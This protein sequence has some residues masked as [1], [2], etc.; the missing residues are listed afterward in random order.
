MC[1][2]IFSL[3]FC[4]FKSY[5][6][7]SFFLSGRTLIYVFLEFAIK[8]VAPIPQADFE[9]DLTVKNLIHHR[10]SLTDSVGGYHLSPPL[11]NASFFQLLTGSEGCPFSDTLL[12]D[13]EFIAVLLP[14]FQGVRLL[15]NSSVPHTATRVDSAFEEY[16]YF[17]YSMRS[18]GAQILNIS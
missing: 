3:T 10:L 16:L 7:V 14:Y 18:P 1:L 13:C 5:N 11:L 9:G 12:I 15:Q 4:N 17:Y 6:K 8:R 2:M